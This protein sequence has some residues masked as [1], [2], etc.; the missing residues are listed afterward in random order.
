MKEAENTAQKGE[1][2]ALKEK[3]GFD[4]GSQV[5]NIKMRPGEGATRLKK[6]FERRAESAETVSAKRAANK[7]FVGKTKEDKDSAFILL[8]D[9]SKHTLSSKPAKNLQDLNDYNDELSKISKD[10][11]ALESNPSA[12]QAAIR[13]LNETKAALKADRAEQLVAAGK[14]DLLKDITQAE[15]RT[16]KYYEKYSEGVVGELLKS[17]DGVYKL[18]DRKFVSRILSGTP[19]EADE[20]AAVIGKNPDLLNKWKEGVIDAYR[21]K[22]Y[23][24]KKFDKEAHDEFIDIHKE[25]LEKF[26][27]DVKILDKAGDLSLRLESQLAKH[28]DTIKQINSDWSGKLNSMDPREVIEF[29]TTKKGGFT[30]AGEEVQHQVSKI[31]AIKK[32]LSKESPAAWQEVQQG[33]SNKLRNSV[34]DIKLKQVDYTKLNKTVTEQKDEIIEMMG[35]PYYDNLVKVNKVAEIATKKLKKI[36]DSEGIQILEAITR[37]TIAPPLSREGR[38]LTALTKWTR[39]QGHKIIADAFLDVKTIEKVAKSA[40]HSR[41]T[42]EILEIAMSAGMMDVTEEE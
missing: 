23:K 10:I 28:K 25:N 8:P 41:S 37:M 39:R 24:G 18:S 5:F 6:I 2:K 7:I 32:A 40:E 26:I 21:K 12:G 19:E 27:P 29:I 35:K 30:T 3:Y 16:A 15:L 42:R 11:R 13:D 20:L 34:Q 4:E 9:G 1:W 33:F 38:G 36:K 14:E 17:K 31:K 22:V